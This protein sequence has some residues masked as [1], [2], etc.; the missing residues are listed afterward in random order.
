MEGKFGLWRGAMGVMAKE[1]GTYCNLLVN[2]WDVYAIQRP[3]G[4]YYLVHCPVIS[5]LI[6]ASLEGKVT[7]GF[8][9]LAEDETARWA[10]ID[11][12]LE[13]GL[14]DL[15]GLCLELRQLGI[16]SY[17]EASRRGGHLYI[18]FE[19]MAAQTG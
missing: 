5:Q 14:T 7:P 13:E 9:A 3:D 16:P 1:F 2:R 6:R 11:S 8:Y 19:P 12:D 17:L 15:Q 18:F 10:C 4:S